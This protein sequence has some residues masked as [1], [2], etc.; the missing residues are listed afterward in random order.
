MSRSCS[1]QSIAAVLLLVVGSVV[2]QTSSIS[3][4]H[5]PQTGGGTSVN[6]AFWNIKWFPGGRPSAS[7]SEEA[8]QTRAVHADIAKLAADV[9]G[10]EEIRDWQSVELAVK[11]LP[12]FKVDVCSNFPAREGQTATQQIAIASR[13]TPMS[14]WAEEWKSGGAITPPR[15]FAF[16]AYEIA[17]GKILLVY[18]V[19][20]KSNRG[21]LVENVAI[22][23]E[24]MRQLLTHMKEMEAAYAKLGSIT[25]VIGG[26]Y[27][28][29][30]D[31]PRFKDE[32]TTK[33]LTN[34]GFRWTWEGMPLEQRVTLP[35]DDRFPAACFDHIYYRGATLKKA[36]ALPTSDT[37]SDHR[38]IRAELEL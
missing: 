17:P 34:I 2:A 6:I 32:K 8:R 29:A 22:R 3:R 14:A 33:S 20:L 16:A 18:A 12:G 23:E 10:F 30:P 26:D 21:E 27:N 11:P 5:A 9:I 38:A 15:G 4:S 36:E 24:S 28:T 13:L 31:D 19:H 37:S 1:R 7:K 35:P 25:W